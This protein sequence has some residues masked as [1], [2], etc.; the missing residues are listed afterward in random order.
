MTVIDEH[1]SRHLHLYR[2]QLLRIPHRAD[3]GL[4]C[5]SELATVPEAPVPPTATM[6]EPHTP[7]DTDDILAADILSG[8]AQD[9][10]SS[11]DTSNITCRSCINFSW[12]LPV[13]EPESHL[14][15]S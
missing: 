1:L 13:S 2:K 3:N 11:T 9:G 7:L 6:D 5:V 8:E 4:V 10:E 15:S 14:C 12:S